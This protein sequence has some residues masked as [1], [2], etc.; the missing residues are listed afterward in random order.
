MPTAPSYRPDP[1]YLSLGEGF[2]DRVSAAA[3]PERVLRFRNQRWARRVGLD[4][5]NDAEWRRAFWSFEPLPDNLPEP[6]ATRYHGHQFRQYNPDLGDGRGFLFA[7]LRDDTGRLL[8]LGTKGSGR[9]P[10]SR[11]GDGRLTLKGG[12][13]ELLATEM[14]EVL[15]VPTSKTFSIF[16]TGE[17]LHRNDEPSPT[18][19]CVLVRLSHSHIRYGTFQ[20]H[21][22]HRDSPRLLRLVEHCVETYYPHLDDRDLPHVLFAATL[23]RAASLVAHWMAAGFVHG[24]LNTDNLNITGESFD[25]G[26]WRFLPRYDPSFTAAYFDSAGLYAYGRQAEAVR[27]NL[28]RL[29]EALVP[30]SPGAP[31]QATLETYDALVQRAIATTTFERLGLR[32]SDP[33]TDAATIAALWSYLSGTNLPFAQFFHDW[34]GGEPSA[35]RARMSPY[36]SLYTGRRFATLRDAMARHEPAHPERLE[37]AYFDRTRPID[38]TVTEVE[39][40]WNR[41]DLYDD[42]RPLNWKVREIR[43]MGAVFDR[44]FEEASLVQRDAR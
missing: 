20:R 15:G 9:T 5:L 14:L 22:Y 43:A 24:V 21:A 33:D 8:D 36:A 31:W 19:A 44:D 2:A 16:E 32:P 4:T 23:S 18:R 12:V 37:H 38:L 1:R 27:W 25:Y 34:Y 35:P 13:R 42:W 3:F 28:T 7:Q 40:I 41:I 10:Y 26:P 17:R 6:L 30:L 39:E 11:G 29:A